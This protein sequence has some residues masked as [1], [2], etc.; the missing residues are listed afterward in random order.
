MRKRALVSVLGILVL[1]IA[2]A[3]IFPLALAWRLGSREE[4]PAFL[5]SIAACVTVGSI[6]AISCAGKH[7]DLGAREG[8]AV[9]GLGWV[10]VS[11]F[12]ALPF[13]LAPNGIASYL[14]AYFETMS[15]FTTT[16]ASVVRDVEA[17]PPGLLLWRSLTHWLGGMGIVVLTVAIL[18]F[19]GAGGCQLLRAELPGPSA[20]KLSP[21]IA[22]T[23]AILWLVYCVLTVAQLLLLWPAM[24]LFDATCHALGTM[25]TGG[26]STRNASLDG[27]GSVYIDAVVTVFMFL[28]GANFVLHFRALT[29]RGFPHP[30]DSEFRF[31][32]GVVL[33]AIALVTAFLSM[34]DFPDREAHPEKYSSFGQC[35]RYASFQVVSIITTTGF[36]T[37]DYEGWPSVCRTVIV[38]LM[39]IGGCA[40]STSGGVKCVRVLMM[41]RFGL[42]EIQRLVR[43][44]A[45][46][47]LR[48]GGH[49]IER[50]VIS[51]VLGFV[52]L[53]LAVCVLAVL[54]LSIVIEGAP[55]SGAASTAAGESGRAGD[56][57]LLTSF[58]AVLGTIG[59][60][61]PGLAGVGP[62]ENYGGL[63]AAGKCIL[64]FL[65]LLG[66]LEIYAVLVLFVPLT[67]RR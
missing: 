54:F 9:V 37:A 17:L 64:I 22:Q 62:V 7:R 36:V 4:I 15:G 26:F 57:A 27:F 50:E 32:F 63:P 47:S 40:G 24:G 35:L 56:A 6:G 1:I 43:P 42:R 14:D 61:G 67:W 33:L 66:R 18:P 20:D 8:F 2:A 41:T 51:R 39:V 53:Y 3:L 21:R 46:I 30:R 44:H 16:G 19:L 25:S 55:A 12:G 29:G 31:Y 45:V 48:I 59:N 58:G 11:A 65:M 10:V 60:I 5:W 34:T 49:V 38:L 52:C 28:A 23:A 13:F